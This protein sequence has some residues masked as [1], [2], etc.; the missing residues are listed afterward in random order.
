[1]KGRNDVVVVNVSEVFFHDAKRIGLSYTDFGR[2]GWWHSRWRRCQSK[3]CS[4]G[5]FGE[6]TK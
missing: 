3:R 4:E 1:M 2:E 5:W 6:P